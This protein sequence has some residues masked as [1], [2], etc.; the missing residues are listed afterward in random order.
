MKT[1]KLY[2]IPVPISA[3]YKLSETLL[4]KDLENIENLENFIS[5]T[6]KIA[7]AFLKDISLKKQI[8]DINIFE[9]NKN[10]KDDELE[11]LLEP[12]FQG[13]NLG[14]ISD[15][16]APSIADPGHR[17]V[18]VAQA[19]GVKCIPLVGPS[20]VFLALM[21]S[22]LNGQSFAFYGYL[23]KERGSKRKKIKTLERIAQNTKQTQMFME[24]PYKN[25]NM[26]EDILDICEEE[27][28]LCIAQQ[29]MG[30]DEYIVTKSIKEWKRER[31][32][33]EKNPCLFLINI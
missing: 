20:S 15:A 23:P 33:L 25:Q 17:L 8:Q 9:L 13:K 18:R 6:P 3:N 19:K 31:K 28:L 14:L 4:A 11:S 16:G 10:T 29:V 5:E 27:T 24:T 26:L 1:G 32:V 21:A 7:R 2:L 12:L 30:E 22:G